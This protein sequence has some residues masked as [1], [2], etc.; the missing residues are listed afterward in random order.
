MSERLRGTVG[1]LI[2]GTEARVEEPD[3]RQLVE[4]GQPGEL[5]VRGPQV[6][7]SSRYWIAFSEMVS[8][9]RWRVRYR[10]FVVLPLKFFNILAIFIR[11][12][13]ISRVDILGILSLYVCLYVDSFSRF[14]TH[15]LISFN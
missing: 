10:Y 2:G 3:T 13:R 6:G 9:S 15:L 11:S 4:P 14:N 5:V 8:M 7:W 12:D 1:K